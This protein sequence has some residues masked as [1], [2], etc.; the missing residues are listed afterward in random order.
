MDAPIT[1][2]QLE[3]SGRLRP[4]A[5]QAAFSARDRAVLQQ[6]VQVSALLGD[7]TGALDDRALFPADVGTVQ[8]FVHADGLVTPRPVVY[9]WTHDEMSVLLAG[10]LAPEPGLTLGS[11]FEI[12]P[13]QVGAWEVDVLAGPERTGEPPRVLVHREFEVRGD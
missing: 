6:A 7:G 13:D 5:E 2:D 9:R 11:T 12:E 4:Q 8:L 1:P 10:T 3:A